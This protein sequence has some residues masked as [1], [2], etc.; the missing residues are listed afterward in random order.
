MIGMVHEAVHHSVMKKEKGWWGRTGSKEGDQ[1]M[2]GTYLAGRSH[3]LASLLLPSGYVMMED[4][5]N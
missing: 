1:G 4:A 3:V 5:R 2:K